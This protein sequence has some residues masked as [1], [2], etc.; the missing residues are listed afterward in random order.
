MRQLRTAGLVTITALAMMLAMSS[1]AMAKVTFTRV[2]ALGV[3]P[4]AKDAL[5]RTPNGELH[6]L[7]QTTTG[8]SPAP[9]GLAT[10]VISPTGQVGPAVQALSGW[11]AGI[12]GLAA[13]PDGSLLGAFGAVSP[14]NVSSMWTIASADDGQTWSAPGATPTAVPQAYGANL[15]LQALGTT[16][17]FTLTVSGGVTT[18]QGVASGSPSSLLVDATDDFAGDVNSAVDASGAVIV[19]WDSLAGSGGDFIRE[20]AP[21]LGAVQEV[22]GGLKDEL[23][24]AA[25]SVGGGVFAPYSADKTHVRLLKYGG[26]SIAVGSVKGLTANTLGVATGLD[27]RIWVMWGDESGIAVTRSNMGVTQFEPIQR[28]KP[29]SF[30]L[31][32]VYGNGSLG[33]LDLFVDQIPQSDIHAPG[34]FYTRVLPL[35]SVSDGVV[36]HHTKKGVVTGYSITVKVTDAGDKVSGAAVKIGTSK[37]STNTAG[38]AHFNLGPISPSQAL[39]VTA[40]GYRVYKAHLKL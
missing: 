16:P 11:T 3:G 40:A 4:Y 28:L 5:A 33:P 25:R 34:G 17:V 8:T 26:G 39:T 1:A 2:F 9:T 18:Q 6:L 27:G 32:R 35:L 38:T 23:Q 7:Y 24:L 10:R 13:L 29:G 37:K 20:A 30:T 14:E 31:Y 19:S 15:N 21:Q 22:P 12:P 36:V